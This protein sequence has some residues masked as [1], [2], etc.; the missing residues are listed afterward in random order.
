MRVV[1][2]SRQ[3]RAEWREEDEEERDQRRTRGRLKELPAILGE[4]RR[5]EE[6]SPR[7]CCAFTTSRIL[8]TVLCRLGQKLED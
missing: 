8:P 1:R 7:I 5:P 3:V 4:K 6:A 2:S